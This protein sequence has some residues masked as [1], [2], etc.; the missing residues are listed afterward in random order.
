MRQRLYKPDYQGRQEDE[1][2]QR[3]RDTEHH[4]RADDYLRR[5]LGLEVLLNPLVELVRL[6]ILNGHKLRGVGERLHTL[7]H[8]VDKG[9]AAAD[10]RPAEYRVFVL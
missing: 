4:R 6:L 8:G 7:Y 3:E 10:E 2:K 5:L 1:E 9:H